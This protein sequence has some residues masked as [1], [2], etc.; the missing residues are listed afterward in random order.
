MRPAIRIPARARGVVM[1]CLGGTARPIGGPDPTPYVCL[2]LALVGLLVGGY[3]MVLPSGVSSR[4]PPDVPGTV[5]GTAMRLLRDLSPQEA[6]PA[7][8]VA[9]Q[10]SRPRESIALTDG[11]MDDDDLWGGAAPTPAGLIL[12]LTACRPRTGVT[13]ADPW[14]THYLARPQLLTRL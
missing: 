7:T 9:P 3:L 12:P 4:R 10:A 13:D 14:P 2:G 11:T 5:V 8:V 1:R 6:H